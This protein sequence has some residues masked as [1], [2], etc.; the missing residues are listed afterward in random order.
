M[1]NLEKIKLKL[2]K[3]LTLQKGATEIGSYEE[4]ANAME[5]IQTILLKYNLQREDVPDKQATNYMVIKKSAD[6]IYLTPKYS[7]WNVILIQGI[8]RLNFCKVIAHTRGSS[9]VIG[10]TILGDALG[11]EL[12]VY[13]Y[14]QLYV[15]IRSGEA[16]AFKKY[17]C[18]GEKRGKFRRGYLMG[19]TLAITDRLREMLE[20]LKQGKSVL[21]D[22][23]S[24]M[25]GAACTAMVLRKNAD[26]DLF[27]NKTFNN[28]SAGKVR[29]SNGSAAVGIGV[30]D[31]KRMSINTGISG[32]SNSKRLN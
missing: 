10:I 4:A 8:A 19:A 21:D 29:R 18:L 5:K 31:G 16:S 1:D 7:Y 23:G 14:E 6:D 20:N 17:E 12:T 9:E 3:L 13:L 28:L 30:M 22:E 15:K 2:Q 26:L 27:V 11:I 24:Q 32:N 25:D